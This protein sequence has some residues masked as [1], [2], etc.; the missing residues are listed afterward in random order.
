MENNGLEKK[1]CP[2]CGRNFETEYVFKIYCS[3]KCASKSQ[4]RFTPEQR[5]AFH[6]PAPGFECGWCGKRVKPAGKDNRSK[7]C[8]DECC[9]K[10]WKHPKLFGTGTRIVIVPKKTRGVKA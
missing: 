4:K 8:S 10:F 2:V 6:T 1:K 3:P 7:F 9:H 5:A